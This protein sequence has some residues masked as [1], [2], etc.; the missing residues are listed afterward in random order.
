MRV[1]CQNTN[2]YDYGARHYDPSL[3]RW[4]VVDHASEVFYELN[5]FRYAFNNPINVIDTDGNIEYPLKGTYV[6]QKN[7]SEYLKNQKVYS[8]G[9]G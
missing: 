9:K 2:L 7:E 1:N 3:G 5:P 8:R 6:V 4:F